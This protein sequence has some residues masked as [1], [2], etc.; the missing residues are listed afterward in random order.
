MFSH[1]EDLN[2]STPQNLS[3][4]QEALMAKR[5]AEAKAKRERWMASSKDTGDVATKPKAK[6]LPESSSSSGWNFIP[7][8]AVIVLVVV[9]WLATHGGKFFP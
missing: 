7:A 1:G 2:P 4:E 9:V 8:V 6:I 3:P 5:D